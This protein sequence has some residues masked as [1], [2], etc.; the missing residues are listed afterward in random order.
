MGLRLAI[1]DY[2]SDSTSGAA[3]NIVVEVDGAA[4]MR[5]RFVEDI[6]DI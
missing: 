3:E 2:T 6:C 4:S 5:G 1:E